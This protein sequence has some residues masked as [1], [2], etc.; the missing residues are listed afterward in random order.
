MRHVGQ[1]T[2]RGLPLRVEREI[3][4]LARRERISLNKAASRLL[5][6]AAG[7]E[8]RE[9]ANDNRDERIGGALDHFIGTWSKSEADGFLRSIKSCEQIDPE[10]WD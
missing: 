8:Q 10:L 4:E 6:K 5:E 9:Q 2:I 1:L 3:R 7:G